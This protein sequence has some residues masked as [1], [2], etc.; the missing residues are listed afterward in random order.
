MIYI[1]GHMQMTDQMFKRSRE[2]EATWSRLER[3]AADPKSA[4][5]QDLADLD[6]VLAAIDAE[7]WD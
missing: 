5:A 2:L 7:D 3:A 1:A 4:N 6:R